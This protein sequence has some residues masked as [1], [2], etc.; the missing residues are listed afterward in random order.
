VSEYF[1]TPYRREQ[2]WS[3]EGIKKPL[4]GAKA[5]TGQIERSDKERE[6]EGLHKRKEGR[7]QRPDLKSASPPSLPSLVQ[8]METLERFDKRVHMC[9][10][11]F[12]TSTFSL[13]TT[14]VPPRR[15]IQFICWVQETFRRHIGSGSCNS[16]I[17]YPLFG[18]A[19]EC[20][21]RSFTTRRLVTHFVGSLQLTRKN[22]I[23]II[24]HHRHCHY[25]YHKYPSSCS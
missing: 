22:T 23:I 11:S 8:R 14:A 20:T 2:A 1:R 21:R 7:K 17:S 16:A 4:G 6:K 15:G 24:N 10:R 12:R 3:K 19:A 18:L 9:V 13:K 25:M 5:A